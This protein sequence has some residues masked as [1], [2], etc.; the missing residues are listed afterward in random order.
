MSRFAS[1]AELVDVAVGSGGGRNLDASITQLGKQTTKLERMFVKLGTHADNAHFRDMLTNERKSATAAARQLLSTIKEERVRGPAVAQFEREYTRFTAVVQKIDQKQT[2]QMYAVTQRERQDTALAAEVARD[3]NATG[4]AQ[5]T[6]NIEF[7]EY[8]L[9]EVSQR[10][11]QVR[12]IESDIRELASMFKDVQMMVDE[13]QV[14]IDV[15]EDNINQTK[16]KVE[17]AHV[18]LEKAAAYQRSIRKRKCCVLLMLLI[19]IAVIVLV[20]LGVKGRF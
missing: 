4:Q 15:S 13:Q 11:A 3:A 5:M 9:D 14:H 18:E 20:V 17:Q 8:N 16:T 6:E 7:L 12:A 2:Q 19:I 1:D 10:H